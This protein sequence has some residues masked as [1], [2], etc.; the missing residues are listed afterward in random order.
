MNILLMM[1]ESSIRGVFN[2]EK[3]E[4]DLLRDDL[5][6][7]TVVRCMIEENIFFVKDKHQEIDAKLYET[8]LI[9]YTE[10]L[11]LN[12]CAKERNV[13]EHKKKKINEEEEIKKDKA[14]F[15]Y[16]YEELEY[17]DN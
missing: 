14:F 1:S 11:F 12:I 8:K 13:P 3:Y 7:I 4:E 5:E 2:I 16:L 10:K 6:R 9:S 17:P 15:K